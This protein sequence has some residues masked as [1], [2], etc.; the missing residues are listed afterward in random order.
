M[1]GEGRV[2]HA[3][4]QPPPHLSSLMALGAWWSGMPR[5]ALQVIQRGLKKKL[6]AAGSRSFTHP[7]F[8]RLSL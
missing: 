6:G 1:S 3:D 5:V 8:L 4:M 7:V 2:H